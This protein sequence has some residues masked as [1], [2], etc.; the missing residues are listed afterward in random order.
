M[1]EQRDIDIIME[2]PIDWERFR[3]KSVLITGATGRLG[4]YLVEAEWPH[5]G[6]GIEYG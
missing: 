3:N 4:M 6:G 1:V 5:E 2:S